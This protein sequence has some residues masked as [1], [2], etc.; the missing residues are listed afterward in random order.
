MTWLDRLKRDPRPWLLDHKPRNP[1][2]DV[3][4][5]DEPSKWVTLDVLQ[6]IKEIHRI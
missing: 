1:P 4:Q 2:F 6:V 5:P 3:G